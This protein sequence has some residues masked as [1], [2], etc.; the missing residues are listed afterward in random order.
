MHAF[1]S[2]QTYTHTHACSSQET[3]QLE[4]KYGAD[5]VIALI[6]PVSLCMVLVIVVIQ[7]VSYYSTQN[8]QFA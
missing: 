1:F 3:L 6:L 4:L 2:Y 5:Q 7:S 8:T